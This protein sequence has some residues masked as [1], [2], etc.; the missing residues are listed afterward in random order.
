MYKFGV[1]ILTFSDTLLAQFVR[2]TRAPK[3]DQQSALALNSDEVVDTCLRIRECKNSSDA[4]IISFYRSINDTFISSEVILIL[5]SWTKNLVY[6]K[7]VLDVRL[8]IHLKRSITKASIAV[9][10]LHERM[11]WTLN[12][13]QMSTNKPRETFI[14][15]RRDILK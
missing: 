13:L 1:V 7:K 3:S 4:F 6:Q 8:I 12:W 5:V 11:H 9:S 2:D 14:T 10:L 15:L